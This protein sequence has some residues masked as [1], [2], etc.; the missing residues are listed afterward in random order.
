MEIVGKL[1]VQY[2]FMFFQTKQRYGRLNKIINYYFTKPVNHKIKL[3]EEVNTRLRH[4]FYKD[5]DLL[6]NML[7]KD[8]LTIWKYDKI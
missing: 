6:S 1:S 2:Y 7:E 8:L 5:L 4:S 3:D